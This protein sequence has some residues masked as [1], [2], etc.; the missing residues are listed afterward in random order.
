MSM[1]NKFNPHSTIY[2][3]LH[4]CFLWRK[5]E[6]TKEQKAPDDP[7][8][9]ENENI[10]TVKK[11]ATNAVNRTDKASS[12]EAKTSL[13]ITK[14]EAYN[15]RQPIP[16]LCRVLKFDCKNRLGHLCCAN[17]SSTI[18]VEE[19][20]DCLVAQDIYESGISLIILY[21]EEFNWNKL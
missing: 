10:D 3:L 7:S 17:F 15:P 16:R 18:E 11:S 19:T 12:E 5:K 6:I 13:K 14:S 2:Q 21:S 8:K 9:K 4:N 1:C 20:E